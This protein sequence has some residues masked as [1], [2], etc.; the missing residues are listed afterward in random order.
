VGSTLALL[1]SAGTVAGAYTYTPYGQATA[2]GTAGTPLQYTGQF[3]DAESGL[4]Y[5]RARYYDPRTALF[6]TVDPLVDSTRT[7]Y[8]YTGDNPLNYT[9]ITGQSWWD[10]GLSLVIGGVVAIGVGACIV[11]EPCGNSR[12][13]RNRCRRW[14]CLGRGWSCCCRRWPR[15]GVWWSRQFG[16]PQL[17][18]RRRT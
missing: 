15:Y 18:S 16:R 7:P 5:L 6:L 9:D 12:R 17:G 14:R 4:I 11:M 13:R 10:V 1:D 3:T 8:A 2:S